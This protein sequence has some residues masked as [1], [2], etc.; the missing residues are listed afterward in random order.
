[1]LAKSMKERI[2]K[3]GILDKAETGQQASVP[4]VHDSNMCADD[5]K[6]TDI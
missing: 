6:L 2:S 3:L 1:M 5:G 4:S